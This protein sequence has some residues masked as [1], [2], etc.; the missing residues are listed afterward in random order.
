VLDESWPSLPYAA[1]RDT[2]ATLHMWTQIVG[3]VALAL[4]PPLNHSWGVALFLTPSGLSTRLLPHGDRSFT[5]ELDLVTHRLVVRV[6]DGETRTLPLVPQTV[7]DFHRKTMALLDEMGLAVRIWPMPVEVESPIRFDADKVH[8]SYE[9]EHA[10]ALWRIL[11]SVERVLGECRCD[12][13]GKCSPVHFFWGARAAALRGEH[14]RAR[15]D[16]RRLGPGVAGARRVEPTNKYR[17]PLSICRA[18]ARRPGGGT[19]K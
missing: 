10:S 16:A 8:G 15:G 6:S 17:G 14:V 12:F 18:S 2:Y 3:K 13:V 4:A 19:K 11:F 1:W 7:A 5:M 9:R